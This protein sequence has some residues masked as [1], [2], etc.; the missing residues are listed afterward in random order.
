M[1]LFSGLMITFFDTA[2]I[3]S[4]CISGS[5]LTIRGASIFLGGF[6]NEFMVYDSLMNRKFFSNQQSLFMYL[7]LMI[8]LASVSI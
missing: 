5:V 2:V 8:I 7:I 4:T 3:Y 6:P 1:I